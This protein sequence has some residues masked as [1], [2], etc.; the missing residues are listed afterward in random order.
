MVGASVGRRLLSTTP[1]SYRA[2][3]LMGLGFLKVNVG[4]ETWMLKG[5]KVLYGLRLESVTEPF[6]SPS[7]NVI[8]DPSRLESFAAGDKYYTFVGECFLLGLMDGEVLNMIGDS[9]SRA[10]PPGLEFMDS[11]FQEIR[12]FRI[13]FY[14]EICCSRSMKVEISS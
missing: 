9:P 14:L 8:D 7:L 2:R 12:I 6:I 13:V 3:G 4:D 5:G 11:D 10:R 1:S